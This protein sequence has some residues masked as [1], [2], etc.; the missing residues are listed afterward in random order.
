MAM[1]RLGSWY[2]FVGW[3]DRVFVIG[4]RTLGPLIVGRLRSDEN[5]G[6]RRR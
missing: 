5:Y 2:Y 3:R 1:V 6:L 4:R